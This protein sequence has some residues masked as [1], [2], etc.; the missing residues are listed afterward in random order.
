M[1]P[2][3]LEG[4]HIR[5]GW[6]RAAWPSPEVPPTFEVGGQDLELPQ[7]CDLGKPS[8]QGD[9]GKIN[10]G[11][12]NMDVLE[13]QGFNDSSDIMGLG[14]HQNVNFDGHLTAIER[15]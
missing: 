4:N 14:K 15:G 8:S 2:D 1:D 11:G 13:Q 7:F 5:R 12:S 6:L 10:R 3:L 9:G